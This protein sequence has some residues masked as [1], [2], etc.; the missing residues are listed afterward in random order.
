[1]ST[2]VDTT[3]QLFEIYFLNFAAV[4][5]PGFLMIVQA[6]FGNDPA[7]SVAIF[8][9][10]LTLNGAVTAGYLGNGLDI[11]PNFSGTIFGIAN[12]LSSLGGFLSSFMVGS[13]TNEK[14][15]TFSQWKI[16]FYILSVMYF[17]GA[18]S[19]AFFGS[20]N[21]QKWNSPENDEE[22]KKSNHEIGVNTEESMPL[23][24]QNTV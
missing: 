5:S 21:L 18:M 6:N 19:F 13:I 8:T 16:I 10:S 12:T 22:K 11:A 17:V 15:G 23:K 4:L 3:S 20:G 2:R 14:S 7:T 24:N 1:M 9:L